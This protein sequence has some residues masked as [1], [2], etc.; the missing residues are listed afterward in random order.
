MTMHI[1][2]SLML[3]QFRRQSRQEETG[4]TLIELLVV[5]LILGIL[6]A[7]AVP[8]FVNQ[9]KYA[10]DATV[11]SDV[12]NAS[13]TVANWDIQN[14]GAIHRIP[15]PDSDLAKS[16]VM[17]PYNR[18]T[19]RGNSADY[20]ITGV[21]PSGDESVEG[22]VYSSSAGGLNQTSPCEENFTPEIA[23]AEDGALIVW[24]GETE[25]PENAGN[26]ESPSTDPDVPAPLP[27]DEE[28]VDGRFV[29][30]GD[31]DFVG[32]EGTFVNCQHIVSN[33]KQDNFKLIVGSHSTTDIQWSVD[34]NAE[35]MTGVVSSN[36]EVPKAFEA[37]K[38]GNM[39]Y[40]V[41]GKTNNGKNQPASAFVSDR[42]SHVLV[43]KL[44]KK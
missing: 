40:R 37:D 4:F 6:T 34:V 1:P 27:P 33:K 10:V 41:Y 22:I 30:C 42:K 11:Q 14:K 31:I 36:L 25:L 21:N 28:P 39:K 9:R 2:Q 15:G 24:P 20:C 16:I 43:L 17:S 35:R 44:T 5:I 12:V 26:P 19:V 7:I 8:F 29:S 3:P 18:V 32:K 13:R 23:P 38:L